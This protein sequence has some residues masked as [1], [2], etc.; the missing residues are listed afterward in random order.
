[1]FS[2]TVTGNAAPIR[3]IAGI[4]TQLDIPRA[5]AVDEVNN[6]IYVNDNQRIL[7]FSATAEGNVAP[8][9]ILRGSPV[10]VRLV[11]DT[12]CGRNIANRAERKS[13]N[14][15][16]LNVGSAHICWVAWHGSRCGR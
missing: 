7:V 4:A 9:R 14:S 12:K 15:R 10:K 16:R 2:A 3:R 11:A 8:L 6:E 13:I 5:I 1:V